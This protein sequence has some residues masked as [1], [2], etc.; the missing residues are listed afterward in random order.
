MQRINTSTA[1]TNK[2]GAGK[3]GFKDGDFGEGIVA[4]QLEAEW[5]DQVQEEIAGVIEGTG[6]A[7]DVNDKHQL[8]AAVLAIATGTWTVGADY[9]VHLLPGGYRLQWVSFVN[10]TANTPVEVTLPETFETAIYTQV[11]MSTGLNQ[12]AI[13]TK[14]GASLSTMMACTNQ[15]GGGGI[16]WVMGK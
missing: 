10:P 14:N 1:D 4:T 16:I 13:A 15:S 3:N 12:Y 6:I 5:Y 7:L 9:G 2:F 11:A 8:L